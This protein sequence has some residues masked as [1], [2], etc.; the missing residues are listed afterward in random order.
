MKP[1]RS[2]ILL[3]TACILFVAAINPF[4]AAAQFNVKLVVTNYVKLHSSDDV[5][6]AG[7]FNNWHPG[8]KQYKLS[9]ENGK[10]VFNL[11]HFNPAVLEF[12]FTRGSWD[13]VAVSS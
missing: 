9:K 13:K 1:F 6:L 11:K 12:K 10:L 8:D 5:F 4:N 3:L 7:N 2:H